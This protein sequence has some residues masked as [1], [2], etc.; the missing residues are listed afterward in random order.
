MACHNLA[1][2]YYIIQLFLG[3]ASVR[4]T[5]TFSVEL[6][7]VLLTMQKERDFSALYLSAI[8][9]DGDVDDDGKSGQ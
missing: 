6:S 2:Y 4:E 8:S 1:Y 5:L 9:P 7:D 3:S